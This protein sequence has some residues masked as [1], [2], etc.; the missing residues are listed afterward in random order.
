MAF[1]IQGL[2]GGAFSGG[3]VGNTFL[4]TNE[5]IQ[6]YGLQSGSLFRVK[7]TAYKNTSV[8]ISLGEGGPKVKSDQEP[9]PLFEAEVLHNKAELNINHSHQ[10]GD[11]RGL[12]SSTLNAMKSGVL[13]FN[14]NQIL[15][16]LKGASNLVEEGSTPAINEFNSFGAMDIAQVY[17]GNSAPE[18]TLSFSLMATTD[19]L[20]EVIVPSL[21]FSYF[22][23]PTLS[24]DKDIT[25]LFQMMD[26]SATDF[27]GGIGGGNQ[28]EQKGKNVEKNSKNVLTEAY[29]AVKNVAKGKW[30]YRVGNAPPF[31]VLSSSNGLVFMPNAHISSV[32]ITYYGPWLE[33][34]AKGSLL[35][36]LGSIA[37]GGFSP[38]QVFPNSQVVGSFFPSMGAEGF[39]LGGYPTHA[40][41]DI[42]FQHT[43][44]TRFG[45][46]ILMSLVGG[47][48]KA[49]GSL[50]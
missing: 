41:V 24:K 17:Q 49:K 40:S 5:F 36:S 13:G 33:A 32:N 23:Y 35:S 27:L 37:G 15:N 26:K 10:W 38:T 8:D 28:S 2:T 20:A 3:R 44:S 43:L 50:G 11:G 30:R 22:S 42:T 16:T 39:K 14:A 6:Q 7:L 47:N 34:P 18:F 12:V 31:W 9:E 25:N 1:S 29:D 21:V 46:E 19:P 4:P 48:Q 45:E